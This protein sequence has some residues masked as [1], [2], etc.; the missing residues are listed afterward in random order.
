MNCLNIAKSYLL[1]FM[2][3]HLGIAALSAGLLLALSKVYDAVTDPLMGVLT[4]R[5]RTPW[6]RRRPYLL[7]GAF[8][9]GG[10]Y[11]AVFMVP[12]FGDPKVAFAYMAGALIVYAT[13][14]TVFNVPY[15]AMSAEMTTDTRA[16]TSLMSY[17]AVASI[18]GGGLIGALAP[19]IVTYFGDNRNGFEKMGL[20]IGG[21]VLVCCLA[22]FFMTSKARFTH[23][24]AAEG[25]P[26][27]TQLR[28]AMGNRPFL[29]LC[30]AMFFFLICTNVI[31]GAT[32]F[33][34]IYVLNE[35]VAWLTPFFLLIT[36]AVVVVQP[37]TLWM[38][39]RW[40]KRNTYLIGALVYSLGVLSWLLASPGEPLWLYLFRAI[41]M[42]FGAGMMGVTVNAMLP[43]TMEFDTRRTGLRREGVL[44]GFFSTIEKVSSALAASLLGVVLGLS[45]FVESDS[46]KVAQPDSAMTGITLSVA[47]IPVIFMGLTCVALLFYDLDEKKLK[48]TERL[49]GY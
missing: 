18:V 9:A 19:W 24:V 31:A 16:R 40:G 4:D 22:A 39:A 43:D 42:G 14:Y 13:A 41:S 5:T 38:S 6:G 17:R 12:E 11:V 7:L 25:I 21:I 46:G 28:T 10:S 29:I 45:G 2:T 34:V 35:P 27:R 37:P 15:L 23:P 1:L 47:V 3:N 32:V 36:V 26:F 49:A 8:L 30:A 33:F 44:A 20:I 48:S